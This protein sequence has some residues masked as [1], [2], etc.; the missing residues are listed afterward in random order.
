MPP[1]GKSVILYLRISVLSISRRPAHPV[2]DDGF[3]SIDDFNRETEEL[4]SLSRS[5]G[6]LD[7]DDDEGGEEE[8]DLF[9][10]VEDEPEAFEED[11]AED[12]SS[13][14]KWSLVLYTVMGF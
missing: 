9:K 1:T 6:G 11:D 14:S 3:F 7:A 2:L 5:K 10:P 8:V 4:E 12:T 13:Y